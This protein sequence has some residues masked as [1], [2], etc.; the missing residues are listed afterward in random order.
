VRAQCA[1][2]FGAM[3]AALAECLNRDCMPSL[4][5][6]RVHTFSTN[7]TKITVTSVYS[8]SLAE[9]LQ[10]SIS[11][12]VRHVLGLDHAQLDHQLQKLQLHV[13]NVYM[14]RNWISHEYCVTV[15]ECLHAITSFLELC[16]LLE[17]HLSHDT[18]TAD[19]VTV[20]A[21][22]WRVMSIVDRLQDDASGHLAIPFSL[23][24]DQ[25]MSIFLLR[26]FERLCRAA[27]DNGKKDGLLFDP[28]E[29]NKCYDKISNCMRYTDVKDV[30][31]DMKKSKKLGKVIVAD[32]E[33]VAIGRN[34]FFHGT[35]RDVALALMF[36][37]GAIGRLL[38]FLGPSADAASVTTVK[39]LLDLCSHLHLYDEESVLRRI[40]GSQGV[41]LPS[42][43]SDI[44]WLRDLLWPS[45]HPSAST[46]TLVSLAPLKKYKETCR[47]KFHD[48][49]LRFGF[50]NIVFY[51]TGQMSHFKNGGNFVLPAAD[52]FPMKQ[53][54]CDMLLAAL[55]LSSLNP[56]VDTF[57]CVDFDVSAGLSLADGKR[58][59][60]QRDSF[61]TG[62]TAEHKLLC[63][64]IE[65]VLLNSRP[66]FTCAHVAVLG[67][68]GMGKSLLVSEAL[69]DMQKVHAAG[70]RGVYFLKLRGR[71]AVSVEEDLV[72]HSRSLGSKIGVTVDSLSSEALM[73]LKNYLAHVR[74]VVVIDDAN[75]EGL[76]TAAQ[77][78][79]V[80]SALYSV[81]VTSQQPSDELSAFQAIHGHFEI[82][83]LAKFDE[84]VSLELLQKVCKLC[85]ALAA[86]VDQLRNVAEQMNHLP[87]AVRLFAEYS[88]SRYQR[89]VKALKEAKKVSMADAMADAAASGVCFDEAIADIK[90]RSDCLACKKVCCESDIVLRIFS[91]WTS[92]TDISE[93]EV[94]HSSDKYPRGLVGT[95]RLALLELERLPVDDTV[96]CRQLLSIL[97][98]CPSL[99][100][101]WS[102]FLGQDSICIA[103]LEQLTNLESLSRIA[104]L[105]Q[106]S[107]LVH[108][109]GRCFNMHQLLQ[110]AVRQEVAGE[111]SAVT[112]I[113]E[114]IRGKDSLAANTYR[115]MLPAAYHI[116]KELSVVARSEWCRDSAS[117]IADLM[118][119]LGGG[120]L[121]VEIRRV[122]AE[123]AKTRGDEEVYIS[124]L[125][126]LANSFQSTGKYNEALDMREKVLAFRL[127]VLPADHPDIARAMGS[128]AVCY[129][130]LGRHAEALD[131]KEKVLAFLRRVLPADHLDIAKNM[132]N[133]ANSYR[134]L[135]RHA[136]ALDMQQQA[137]AI[138]RRVLP[139]DHP[140]IADSMGNLSVCYRD[141]GRHAEALDMQ[142]QVFAFQRLYLL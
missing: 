35:K 58:A 24:V 28:S 86:A 118:A 114:R 104:V 69:L 32:Y 90:F 85:T 63:N 67:L 110:R 54:R 4:M 51:C 72:M 91:D 141:L 1:N 57:G 23:D 11:D 128:L 120:A 26:S 5:P 95:V 21:E 10:G 8:C 79:P 18:L 133:L 98:L 41:S 99:S 27:E 31:V 47:A 140:D 100:T 142:E 42:D 20:T 39:E 83:E 33:F 64:V 59:A 89:E 15:S 93:K 19:F 65:A 134:D 138:R 43:L 49:L 25:V 136:E 84:K 101:P 2:C 29:K 129:K 9:A 123:D 105:V 70:Q 115:E 80:S 3:F 111:A 77:W 107:G 22:L 66:A 73:K 116:V 78:I 60:E 126:S 40:A 53:K 112:L 68:P 117:R 130:D 92:S 62:R 121:E 119:W 97:A 50:D 106:R 82:M 30:I 108:L 127:R 122:I 17:R 16:G 88:R 75:V 94:F 74:F 52:S 6:L 102:L 48:V 124:A 37:C 36:C 137:L 125:A 71:G 61:F 132:G 13:R 76:Q 56:P 14:T 81:I 96:A 131:M 87:V 38:R 103:G 139:V 12:V 135:G 34:M 44:K 113:D 46:G 45:P 109:Q 7:F 55:A